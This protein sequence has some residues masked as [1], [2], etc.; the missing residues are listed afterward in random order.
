MAAFKDLSGADHV[1]LRAPNCTHIFTPS[2]M[3]PPPPKSNEAFAQHVDSL[4]KILN[5]FPVTAKE[6]HVNEPKRQVVIWATAIPEFKEEAKGN[7]DASEWDYM[8]EYIFILDMDEEGKIVRIVEFLDSLATARL[9]ELMNKAR[10]NLGIAPK[11]GW[12]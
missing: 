9:R 4:K 5:H 10:E 1:S 12:S 8:G 11:K 3:N 6:I 7:S 2:S